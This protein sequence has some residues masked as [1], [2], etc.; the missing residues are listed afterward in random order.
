MLGHWGVAVGPLPNLCIFDLGSRLQAPRRQS[1]GC[2]CEQN[3]QNLRIYTAGPGGALQKK[4]QKGAFKSNRV[5]GFKASQIKK[6]KT[7]KY[8]EGGISPKGK[9]QLANKTNMFETSTNRTSALAKLL[10]RRIPVQLFRNAMPSQFWTQTGTR[11]TDTRNTEQ[12]INSETKLKGK[13]TA[14]IVIHLQKRVSWQYNHVQPLIPPYSLPYTCT[15]HPR[16]RIIS[17]FR[18]HIAKHWEKTCP[19]NVG[20]TWHSVTP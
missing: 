1:L 3:L 13:Q 18:H 5:D 19:A 7:I 17:M 15:R 11:H 20:K 6:H 8:S 16:D 4:D 9:K 12:K 14:M 2:S 10:W